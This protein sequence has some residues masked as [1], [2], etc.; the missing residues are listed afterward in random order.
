MSS[1]QAQV[2]VTEKPEDKDPFHKKQKRTVLGGE[3]PKKGKKGEK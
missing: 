1:Q 2:Q 3:T